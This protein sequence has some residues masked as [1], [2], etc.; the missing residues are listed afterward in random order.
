MVT[1]RRIE[2]PNSAEPMV[3]ISMAKNGGNS[4][5]NTKQVKQEDKL[6]YTLVNGQAMRT[7]DAPSDLLPNAKLVEGANL[8]KKQKKKLKQKQNQMQNQMIQQPQHS[9]SFP[10]MGG[11]MPDFTPMPFG[12]SAHLK[13]RAPTSSS[14]APS[15]SSKPRQPLPLDSN[16]KVDLDRLQLPPGISITRMSGPTPERKY[17]PASVDEYGSDRDQSV[18]PLPGTVSSQPQTQ[19]GPGGMDYSAME[20]L[21][22]GLNGP[23]VIVVDTSSLKTKEEEEREE[24]EKKGKKKKNKNKNKNEQ[25]S[26]PIAKSATISSMPSYLMPGNNPAAAAPPP[27]PTMA[28]SIPPSAASNNSLKSGPQVLIKNVNGKVT[29]TPVPGTGATPVNPDDLTNKKQTSNKKA[30]PA[31]NSN[32]QPQPQMNGKKSPP[33]VRQLTTVMDSSQIQKSHSVP[34]VNGHV[35]KNQMKDR[36]SNHDTNYHNLLNDKQKYSFNAADGDDPDKVFAPSNDIDM[37]LA[38]DSDRVVEQYKRFLAEFPSPTDQP[39]VRPKVE[40]D[41]KNIFKKKTTFTNSNSNL[42]A[43]GEAVNMTTTQ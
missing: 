35:Q 29:I 25:Q 24:K 28:P 9:Q 18:L 5:S 36:D 7:P 14:A 21:P 41:M 2:T 8:S 39:R 23:N 42:S 17:F 33:Q 30:S 3:T 12:T 40:L 37:D 19:T 6:L 43:S 27:P 11:A 16:G 26:E 34:N 4:A 15:A 38:D 20:G 10:M 1:I 22:P 13:P 31:P 32:S